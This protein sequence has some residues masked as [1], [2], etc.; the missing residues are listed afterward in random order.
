MGGARDMLAPI[1]LVVQRPHTR[2]VLAVLVACPL[3]RVNLTTGDLQ[4]IGKALQTWMEYSVLALA[5][6]PVIGPATAQAG[7]NYQPSQ[8]RRCH[9]RLGCRSE[10]SQEQRF[11]PPTAHARKSGAN[12]AQ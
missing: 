8:S 1:L 11:R 4:A 10:G 12:T 6:V 9:Q 2:L 3:A 5:S 7:D